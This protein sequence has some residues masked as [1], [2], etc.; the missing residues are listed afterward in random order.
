MRESFPLF[1]R[2]LSSELV[3]SSLQRRAGIVF[4]YLS[5]L[6]LC[7]RVHTVLSLARGNPFQLGFSDTTLGV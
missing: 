1:S 7:F 6:Q 5:P 2:V 3:F 4:N